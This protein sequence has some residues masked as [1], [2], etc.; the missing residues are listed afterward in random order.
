M[1][2][3]YFDNSAT[4]KVHIKAAEEAFKVMTELYGN[5]SS[6]HT[7]GSE[8]AKLMLSA[9]NEI[10]ASLFGASALKKLPRAPGF[11]G[12]E[13][14]GRLIFTSCGTESNNL[15]IN[16]VL[17]NARIAKPRVITTDSEHP[18]ILQCL[19]KWE[20]KIFA[21]FAVC[22]RPNASDSKGRR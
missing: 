14:Y 9:R 20:E 4:T 13:E 8:A 3:I 15:A 2:E 21:C 1:S 6:I 18:S 5:P 22:T 17:E 12:G 16:S 19:E 7:K 10:I 11:R